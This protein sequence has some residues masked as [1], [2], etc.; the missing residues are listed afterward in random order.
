MSCTENK[1]MNCIFILA[2][3]LGYMDVALNGSTYYETPNIQRLAEKGVTFTNAYAHPLCSPT[4]SAL[5]TGQYP[6]RTMINAPACHLPDNRVRC[7]KYTVF[8]LASI[9]IINHF[10][11]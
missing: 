10:Y 2:D 4:R 7:F 8:P 3:D 9:H 1:K 5:L 6:H 11:I